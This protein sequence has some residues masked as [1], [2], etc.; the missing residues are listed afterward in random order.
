LKLTGD[1][2]APHR[3]VAVAFGNSRKL[4]IVMGILAFSREIL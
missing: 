4:T 2:S 1:L 3:A